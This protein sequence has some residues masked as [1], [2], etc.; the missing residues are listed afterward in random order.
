MGAL[1]PDPGIVCRSIRRG[2]VFQGAGC[3]GTTDR[4]GGAG[5]EQAVLEARGHG[6]LSV[7][8]RVLFLD[9]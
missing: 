5:V 1:R 3:F 2:G 8:V 4:A 9:G 7:S 6:G